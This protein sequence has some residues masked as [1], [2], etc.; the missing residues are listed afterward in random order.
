VVGGDFYG[1]LFAYVVVVV[2]G[3]LGVDLLAA[4]EG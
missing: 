4:G 3:E 2:A 1:D